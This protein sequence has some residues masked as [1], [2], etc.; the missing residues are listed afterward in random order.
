MIV[1]DLHQKLVTDKSKLSSEINYS[2]L[3]THFREL[4]IF[5][6]AIKSFTMFDLHQF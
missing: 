4:N 3:I 6:L 1:G 5:T 2:I